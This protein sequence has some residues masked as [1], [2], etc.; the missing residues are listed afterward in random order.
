M[1]THKFSISEAVGS[2]LVQNAELVLT[3]PD[4]SLLRL[5]STKYV[6]L[7]RKVFKLEAF[8]RNTVL[9]RL[10]LCGFGGSCFERYGC[11]HVVDRL[12]D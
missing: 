10:G 11:W 1:L 6:S 12:D 9:R 5:A 2:A 3:L 7:V 8:G 4:S